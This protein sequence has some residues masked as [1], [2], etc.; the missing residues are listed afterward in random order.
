MIETWEHAMTDR[1]AVSTAEALRRL[2]APGAPF[3]M[4]DCDVGGRMMRVY[5]N[6][7]STLRDIFFTAMGRPDRPYLYFESDELSYARVHRDAQAL[8]AALHHRF[9]VRKGD[10][11]AICMRNYPE[12]ALAYWATIL[13]G[14]IVVPINAWGSGAEM[15]YVIDHSGS[16][17]VVADDERIERLALHFETLGLR[18]IVAVR[19]PD[20]TGAV[21]HGFDALVADFQ[22]S[23][24][25][26]DPGLMPDDDAT[27]FY[28]S[29]TTGRPKGAVGSHRNAI[30][31]IV[32]GAFNGALS[33]M[34]RTGEILT[35]DP[36]MVPPVYLY[37]GPLFHVGGCNSGLAATM[38]G[39][40]CMVLMY[41][42]NVGQ[43]LA[44]IEQLKIGGLGAVPTMVWQMLEHPDFENYD[45]S[46]LVSAAIGGAAA[47]PELHAR[48]EE[49]LPQVV[50]ATG[51]GAT[52]TSGGCTF[53]G[54]L[55][56]AAR[57]AG[58]GVPT[59]V[60]DVKCVDEAGRAV[61]P[62]VAGELC[63]RGPSILRG[64]WKDAAATAT[65][66]RDG[67]FHSGDIAHIDEEGRITLLD[68]A[69]D[70]I[71]RGGENVYSIEVEDALMAHDAVLAAGVFGLPDQI[72]GETVAAVVQLA[73]GSRLAES[74]LQAF[75][76]TRLAYFKIPA[77]IATTHDEL[78]K[79]ETGKIL[80]RVL[81]DEWIAKG[82]A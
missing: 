43:A 56:Y 50:P 5:S 7:P 78:P 76:A 11:V 65:A 47:G 44:L 75:A 32:S 17:I 21:I 29:G 8:A 72:L 6:A 80:K 53:N 55:D 35:P 82:A 20:R 64:Y 79:N 58:V 2:T 71:I 22:D 51:Y 25:M 48:L 30:S 54:G 61:A 39:G 40:A 63:L 60:L 38:A 69:K 13:L 26:P 4:E 10:R 74:E 59:P 62:G 9:G 73:P 27:I 34:R 15:A 28:T 36:D 18:A 45:L 19:A 14:A 52:E 23:A 41:R 66:F 42:W 77:L 46:S 33:H 12:W 1:A 3:A 37:G 68:R 16:T 31:C 24:P 70:M 49:K 81:R 57:P 67:W